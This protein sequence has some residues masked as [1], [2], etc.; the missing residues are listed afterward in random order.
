MDLREFSR[1]DDAADAAQEFAR[2]VAT[3][4][5]R[6]G[7]RSSAYA[8]GAPLEFL[9]TAERAF[10][11]PDPF[12]A[13]FGGGIIEQPDGLRPVVFVD[14]RTAPSTKSPRRG[15]PEVRELPE[16]A[17]LLAEHDIQV[18]LRAVVLALPPAH[19]QYGPGRHVK[20]PGTTGT[21]GARVLTASGKDGILTAGHVAPMGAVMRNRDDQLADT[22]FSIDPAQVPAAQ[23]TADVAVLEPHLPSAW[24]PGVAVTGVATPGIGDMVTLVGDVSGH[25]SSRIMA[26]SP[27]PMAVPI[28]RDVGV[29]VPHHRELLPARRLGSAG[30]CSGI[31]RSRRS[32][33]RGE[34][35][36]N[37]LCAEHRR[38]A[39]RNRR[40]ALVQ[41]LNTQSSAR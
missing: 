32:P 16:I 1:G 34:R 19:P 27:A 3:V 14:Q 9:L 21:L 26:A 8:L 39:R 36:C 13:V 5:V 28:L 30:D 6:R 25:Q 24:N 20:G 15:L 7:R 11:T 35:R 12:T 38:T 2:A 40:H 17:A 23:V 10:V 18:P 31:H 4:H 22:A 41:D 29:G 37:Q 33:C